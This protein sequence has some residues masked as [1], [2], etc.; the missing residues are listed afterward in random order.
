MKARVKAF[1]IA[2]AAVLLTAMPA[3]AQIGHEP[4]KSPY[5]DLEYSQEVTL[6]GGYLHTRHD[7]AGIAPKDRPIVGVRYEIRLTGPL[8]FSADL[9]GG[10][11]NR[12]VIDP[13]KP[14]A[15]RKLGT[16]SNAVVAADMALA[17][18]LPGERSW[19]DLVPQIRAGLGLVSSRAKDDSSGFAFGTR[20][21][22]TMG[23]GVKY[24]PVGRRFQL[25]ADVTDRIFKLDYPD[26]YYRLSSDNT[27]VLPGSTAKS[28]YT[29]HTALT[30][31][32]SYL[33]AR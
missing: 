33:F 19:H 30:V 18:N 31:G 21:A 6:L 13:L 12:D 15:T 20:F 10:G 28:F 5:V 17:M 29:H 9:L 27:A 26:A 32:V 16:Q 23:G 14:T 1:L 8:A 2:A 11:G 25:R 3:S 24:V 7:P 4:A 22:F